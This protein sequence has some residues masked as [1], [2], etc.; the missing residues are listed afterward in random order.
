MMTYYQ[1]ETKC[2]VL[3]KNNKLSKLIDKPTRVTCTSATLLD[4][5]ITN[6]P[7]LVLTQSVVPQVISDHDL[8]SIKANFRKPKRQ[9]DS[10]TFR[11][12][13]KYEY[14]KDTLCELLLLEA[15]KLNQLMET[16][17]FDLQINS[18]F[19]FLI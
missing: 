2:V 17:D 3:Q 8:I 1:K 15:H 7:N 4:M 19:F 14:Y 5:I 6:R 18:F 12:L 13:D 16:D 10:K 11:H 9:P